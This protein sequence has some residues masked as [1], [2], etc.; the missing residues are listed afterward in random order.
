DGQDGSSDAVVARAFDADL[1]PIGGEN[2]L[3]T[4]VAGGQR[5]PE[6]APVG[7][8]G[9]VVAW[10][11]P[12]SGPLTD[13]VWARRIGLDAAPTSAELQVQTTDAITDEQQ[14]GGNVASD[15]FVVSWRTEGN[16]NADIAGQ[17]Y[18]L[19]FFANGFETGDTTAWSASVP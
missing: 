4:T 15:V 19:A 17:R 13:T 18:E 12:I 2:L 11:G 3:N 6:V 10:E 16:T 7:A 5:N 8:D 14:I 9:F 1:L